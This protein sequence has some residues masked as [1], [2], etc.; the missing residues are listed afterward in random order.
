LNCDSGVQV[1]IYCYF[2]DRV[3]GCTCK[4]TWFLDST[5]VNLPINITGISVLEC[6]RWNILT[7][8][9][10]P[11]KFFGKKTQHVYDILGYT[12]TLAFAVA[13]RKKKIKKILRFNSL[14]N[15]W[16]MHLK[17]A[18]LGLN[19]DA[20]DSYWIG[21]ATYYQEASFCVTS[22]SVLCPWSSRFKDVSNLFT[23]T[24]WTKFKM[25]CGIYSFNFFTLQV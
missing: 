20:F 21:I 24:I 11:K 4:M 9:F 22:M 2:T 18:L 12:G 16:K 8:N 1:K 25:H 17:A 6:A 5:H 19:F 7:L 23:H 14:I 15:C 10:Q 3:W 13:H